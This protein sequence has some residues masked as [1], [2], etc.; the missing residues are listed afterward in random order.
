MGKKMY[1]DYITAE[2]PSL[3]KIYVHTLTFSCWIKAAH[4][5]NTM[6]KRIE[7]YHVCNYHCYDFQTEK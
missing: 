4:S 3:G 2:R 6:W 7:K 5:E 1:N